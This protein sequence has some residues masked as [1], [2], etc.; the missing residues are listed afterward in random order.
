[1]A[2]KKKIFRLTFIFA[3]ALWCSACAAGSPLP[4]LT[5]TAPAAKSPT[6]LPSAKAI[7]VT[8]APSSLPTTLAATPTKTMTAL[9][10]QPLTATALPSQT[11]KTANAVRENTPV[12][13]PAAPISADNSSRLSELAIWGNGSAN[14]LAYSPDG[15]TLAVASSLGIYLYDDNSYRLEVIETGQP[16]ISL[17]FSPD[18]ETLAVGSDDGKIDFWRWKNKKHIKTLDSGSDQPI[19]YIIYS[20]TGD[21]LGYSQYSNESIYHVI[22][23]QDGIKLQIGIQSYSNFVFSSDEKYIYYSPGNNTILRVSLETGKH[24]FFLQETSEA[25]IFTFMAVSRDGKIVAGANQRAVLWETKSNELLL[26]V[27]IAGSPSVSSQHTSNCKVMVDGGYAIYATAMDISPDDQYF[28]IGGGADTIQIRAVRDGGLLG[29]TPNEETGI[30]GRF[31]I[32]K[33]LFHPSKPKIIVLHGDGLIEERDARTAKLLQQIAGHTNEYTSVVVSPNTSSSRTLLA[34]GATLGVVR[35]WDLVSGKIVNEL[36]LQSN[37]LTFS[38]DG[39]ILA[40]GSDDWNIHLVTLA[41]GKQP[42]PV[43]GHSS[44]VTGLAYAP[45]GKSL[46]SIDKD[47]RLRIWDVTSNLPKNSIATLP[48]GFVGF[49]SS[50]QVIASPDGKLFAVMANEVSLLKNTNGQDYKLE[51]LKVMDQ[52]DINGIAF[53]PD[54]KILAGV[55]YEQIVYVYVET[56]ELVKNWKESGKWIVF[57]PDGSILA[58]GDEGGNIILLDA[59]T[60]NEL[61]RFEAHRGSI[62]GLAFSNDGRILISTSADGTVRLWGVTD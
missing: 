49:D 35:M 19:E 51:K 46:V 15:N 17:A 5:A 59:Q 10:T 48:I 36:E 52:Y 41:G 37:A 57:S 2:Q 25:D 58:I 34:V 44:P 3:V 53:S 56:G 47:C 22:Y 6:I 33:V 39:A 30:R 31:G 1:M 40:I 29:S 14:D 20:P 28:V 27:D 42:D 21:Y 45:D 54:S 26:Q 38:P 18:G 24:W 43:A 4:A 8:P 62:T 16:I 55:G 23:L 7:L 32:R 12:P 13:Q 50:G 9:A 61:L 11:V 60:G